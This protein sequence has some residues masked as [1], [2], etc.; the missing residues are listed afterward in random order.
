MLEITA[1]GIR[2]LQEKSALMNEALQ[3]DKLI[4]NIQNKI[5]K[6]ARDGY[7]RYTTDSLDEC[8]VWLQEELKFNGFT[9]T[10]EGRFVNIKWK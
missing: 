1:E 7:S 8:P 10:V 2:E 3:K 9:V 5:K 6:N 4:T